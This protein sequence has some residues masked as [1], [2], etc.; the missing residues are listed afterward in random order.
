[1]TG[2]SNRWESLLSLDAEGDLMLRCG[3]HYPSHRCKNLEKGLAA[4]RMSSRSGHDTIFDKLGSKIGAQ[5]YVRPTT[6][7]HVT[8]SKDV[9]RNDRL[10]KGM[11]PRSRVADTGLQK[12]TVVRSLHVYI[13]GCCPMDPVFVR[14]AWQ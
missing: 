1:M 7:C 4:R 3:L 2:R 8:K 13:P 14:R 5:K 9:M 11:F 6:S 10:P 12:D